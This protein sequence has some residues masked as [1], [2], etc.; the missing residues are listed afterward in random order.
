MIAA[1]KTQEGT[2]IL[3]KFSS[4]YKATLNDSLRDMGMHSAFDINRADFKGMTRDARLYISRVLHKTF[5][6]VNEVGTEAAAAT[7]TEM[8]ITSAPAGEPFVFK[9]DRPFFYAI[10]DGQTGL[11]LFAGLMYSPSL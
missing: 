1:L 8:S 7:G 10:R 2:V 4:T 3:P 6:E 9:A 11:I 5:V